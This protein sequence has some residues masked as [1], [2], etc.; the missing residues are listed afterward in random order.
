MN[1]V[2][3]T[4]VIISYGDKQALERSLRALQEQSLRGVELQVLLLRYETTFFE[5]KTNV[6]LRDVLPI[7]LEKTVIGQSARVADPHDL[8]RRV[9]R[10]QYITFVCEGDSLTQYFVE[11]ML[12]AVDV[13]VIPLSQVVEVWPGNRKVTNTAINETLLKPG[14]Y[15]LPLSECTF[16]IMRKPIGKLFR[17]D[18][19][20]EKHIEYI[21]EG[22]WLSLQ[23]SLALSGDFEFSK[24]PAAVGATYYQSQLVN[25]AQP[26]SSTS[27]FVGYAFETLQKLQAFRQHERTEIQNEFLSNIEAHFMLAIQNCWDPKASRSALQAIADLPL[28]G[29]PWGVLDEPVDTIAI[30]ANF[31]PYAGTAGLVAGKRI[32]DR[33]KRVDLISSVVSSRKRYEKDLLMTEPYLRNHLIHGE[34]IRGDNDVN[35]RHF[36]EDV[37]STIEFWQ[38]GGA[39][40]RNIYSRSMMPH[41]HIVAAAIK[42]KN[43]AWRWTAEFS[44]PNS[45]DA[46]GRKRLVAFEDALVFPEFDGWGT[47]EQQE[48]L[49]NDLRLYRWAELL[50]YFF[51]DEVVFTNE[52]QKMV[53][54]QQAPAEY[55]EP[56]KAKSVVVH[57][58]TL[59]SGYYELSEPDPIT[60]DGKI[61][62]AYF[63]NFYDTRG[64]SEIIEA[65][66]HL[67]DAELR[68]FKLMIYTGSREERIYSGLPERVRQILDIRP[69]LDYLKSLAT[70][71][72]MD[73]LIVNDAATRGCFPANPFLPSKVSDYRGSNAKVWA[74]VE[75]GSVLSKLE[76]DHCSVLGDMEGA[77]QV[78]RE[79][80]SSHEF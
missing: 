14:D 21:E 72:R 17:C 5:Q 27:N 6:S 22:D 53:M 57:H 36:L 58:P 26:K 50:P 45:V 75:A 34:R 32:V 16:D 12:N 52:N 7:S 19:I 15:A 67:E 76:S 44:D 77:L 73:C 43:P 51:A 71:N 66:D 78:L 55:R 56:I 48:M 63:G 35:F 24:F 69:R 30:V 20:S 47:P 1:N 40:Y 23:V 8:F 10:S 59:P 80:L 3:L 60:S 54:L 46:Q 68:H 4:V 33:G 79:I 41:S 64:L 11:A 61:L 65:L 2:S 38:A 31:A 18:S 25:S 49:F 74:V 70:M 9:R 13:N 29:L 39:E 28:R 37:L 42:R 62:L